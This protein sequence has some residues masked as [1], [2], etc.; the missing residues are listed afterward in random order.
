MTT[1][2]LALEIEPEML[3]ME[4][5]VS[6][7]QSMPIDLIGP[8]RDKLF[9]PEDTIGTATARHEET[10]KD[11]LSSEV[12]SLK[13]LIS[14]LKDHPH[15]Y[16]TNLITKE[17]FNQLMDDVFGNDQQQKQFYLINLKFKFPQFVDTIDNYL[18]LSQAPGNIYSPSRFFS[19]KGPTIEDVDGSEVVYRNYYS[20]D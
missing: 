1:E 18:P 20:P 11:L 10:I 5:I 7:S 14:R 13:Q 9:R 16:L 8:C 17:N 19:N 4:K 6:K 12:T 2:S 3:R 15:Y